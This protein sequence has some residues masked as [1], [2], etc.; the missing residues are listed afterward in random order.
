M[1]K[2]I[3]NQISDKINIDSFKEAYT[4]ELLYSDY[5]ELF[6]EVGTEQY[7][8]IFTYGVVCFF[9]HEELKISEFSKIISQHCRYFYDDEL[10]KEYKIDPNAKELKFGYNKAEITYFDIEALRVIMLNIAQSVALDYYFQKTRVLLEET[11]K[12]TSILEKNGKLALSDKEL[13]KFIGQTHNLKNQIVENL[14]IFDSAPE[15]RQSDYLIKIDYDLKSALYM[16]K[17]SQSIHE[18]LQIIREHLEYFSGILNHSDF[19][20]I[21]WIIIALL[22]IFVIDIIIGHL[23]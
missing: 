6:Y 8:S 22:G 5:I 4:A 11:N 15:T 16:E 19:M 1:F 12:H 3:A 23:F 14:H 17:R 20:K 7:V 2:I 18:E 13:K 9:N 21:E 10:T